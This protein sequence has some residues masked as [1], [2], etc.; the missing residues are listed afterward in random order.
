MNKRKSYSIEYKKGIVE[1]SQDKNLTAFCK[2]R[3]LDLRMV[4]KWRSD[5]NKLNQHVNE[6]NA[7]KRKCGSGQQPLYSELEVVMCEW[8]AEKR[9][10]ALVVCRADSQEFALTNAPQFGI[11]PEDFKHQIIGW[12]ISSCDMHNLLGSQ[13]PCLNWKMLRLLNVHSHLS[14]LLME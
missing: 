5:Y 7:K 2:E 6:G 8:V 13:Q 4:R 10:K 9:A 3:N 1:E 12:I 14:H 11:L